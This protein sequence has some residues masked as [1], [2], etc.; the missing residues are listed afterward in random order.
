[1]KNSKEYNQL[2]VSGKLQLGEKLGAEVAKIMNKAMKSANKLLNP[3][4]YGVNIQ[5]D[6]YR[7]PP[8]PLESPKSEVTNG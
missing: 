7:V 6:F 1:M 5:A 3:V 8:K 2:P 4:G